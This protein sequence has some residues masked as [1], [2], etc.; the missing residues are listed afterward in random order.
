MG[1]LLYHLLDFGCIPDGLAL[2]NDLLSWAG[3]D[4]L[5]KETSGKL[6]DRMHSASSIESEPKCLGLKD[7]KQ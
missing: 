7:E 4:S 6:Y 2:G 5:D 3:I 1:L